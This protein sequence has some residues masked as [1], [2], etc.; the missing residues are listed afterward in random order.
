MPRH[1]TRKEF[2]RRLQDGPKGGYSDEAS[3]MRSNKIGESY[4]K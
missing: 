2:T 1:V 3:L 4:G